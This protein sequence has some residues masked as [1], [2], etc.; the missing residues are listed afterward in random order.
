[1]FTCKVYYSLL[2]LAYLEVSQFPHFVGYLIDV[3]SASTP[4]LDVQVVLWSSC[5]IVS[6]L[7]TSAVVSTDSQQYLLRETVLDG[8]SDVLR[9][10]FDAC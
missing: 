7:S 1:M 3:L 4:S 2:A 8:S 10:A 6:L 9:E 5:L